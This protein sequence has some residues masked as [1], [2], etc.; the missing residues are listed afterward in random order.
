MNFSNFQMLPM[1][2]LAPSPSTDL[3]H[4]QKS[5]KL[6]AMFQ[7]AGMDRYGQN[8]IPNDCYVIASNFD[9]ISKIDQSDKHMI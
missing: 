8:Y 1:G 6:A 2:A 5:N 9:E 4:C 3:H 7:H